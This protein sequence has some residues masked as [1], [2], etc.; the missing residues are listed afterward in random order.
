MV[1][2]VHTYAVIINNYKLDFWVNLTI[3]RSN[4]NQMKD[5]KI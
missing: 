4:I 1:H 2:S 3:L 5:T